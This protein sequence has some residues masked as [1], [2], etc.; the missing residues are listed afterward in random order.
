MLEGTKRVGVAKVTL[1][2]PGAGGIEAKITLTCG[3]EEKDLD[4]FHLGREQW[5]FAKMIDGK[6]LGRFHLFLRETPSPKPEKSEDELVEDRLDED[7]GMTS[8]TI[9]S[10]GRT[11]T[12]TPEAL[13]ALTRKLKEANREDD[14]ADEDVDP[15]DGKAPDLSSAAKGNYVILDTVTPEK[16]RLTEVAPGYYGLS[17]V[18]TMEIDFEDPA[19]VQDFLWILRHFGCT[20]EGTFMAV[21]EKD[22]FSRQEKD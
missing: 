14:G 7:T 5:K 4:E 12:T 9:T 10:G 19:V 22:L 17:F 8:V 20:V 13:Q 16:P 1:S 18:V 15:M 6:S 21:I 11:V 2:R 3:I